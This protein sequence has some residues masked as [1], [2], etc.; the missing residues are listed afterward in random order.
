MGVWDYGFMLRPISI[1]TININYY[2]NMKLFRLLRDHYLYLPK[3]NRIQI[4]LCDDGSMIEPLTEVPHDWK[5]YRIKEDLGWNA[6]GARNLLMQETDT[7]WNINIDLD[8]VLSPLGWSLLQDNNFIDNLNP[9]KLHMLTRSPDKST[10]TAQRFR[11]NTIKTEQYK[12]CANDYFITKEYFWAHNGYDEKC[13]GYAYGGD[14]T[15]L[16]KCNINI[17][18]NFP[19]LY[20]LAIEAS[21]NKPL[22]THLPKYVFSND[23]ICFD[24]E[25]IQ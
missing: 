11:N 2:N 12:P 15:L 13:A 25:R 5:V 1:V 4:S 23:R 17:L 14:S 7:D 18:H 19:P 20:T 22:E 3:N 24:W 6:E 10:I 9:Y 16:N 8:K 21:C